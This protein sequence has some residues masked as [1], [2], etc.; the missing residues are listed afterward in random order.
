VTATSPSNG[1]ATVRWTRPT[2]TGGSALTSQTVVAYRVST[3]ARTTYTVSAT[4]TS[5]TISNLA[6]RTQYQFAVIATNVAGSS[7]ESAR[8]ASVTIR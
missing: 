4:A 8:S 1:R 7:P 6:R 3:G 2:N 5:L